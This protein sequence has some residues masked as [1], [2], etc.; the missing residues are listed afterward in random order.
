MD[1][2]KITVLFTIIP[3][4]HKELL[5]KIFDQY[6]LPLNLLF[7]GEG[8]ATS[9]LMEMFGLEDTKKLVAISFVRERRI[10]PLYELL[11]DKLR[12]DQSGT[13]I[14]FTLP[15]SS[16]SGY[17]PTILSECENLNQE[18]KEE[19]FMTNAYELIVTIVSNGYYDQVME[20]A[21]AVGAKGGTVIHAKG[22]GSSEVVK[23]LGI[24]IQPEKDVV[25]ILADKDKR[26]AMMEKISEKAG[27]NT[28][29]KGI[30]FSVPI[31]SA[32]GL[33]VDF[34]EMEQ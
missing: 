21:K 4:H 33:T 11:Q 8:T 19:P 13:G 26:N 15:L 2:Q 20:A 14:A 31:T 32:L 1:N 10:A 9:E 7:H 22:L 5:E 6:R 24:T 30:S 18:T 16:I 17:L 27:L 3:Y 23:F 28:P 25:L 29:G 34:S 12:L